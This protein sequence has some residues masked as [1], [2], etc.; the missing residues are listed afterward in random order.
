M[1]INFHLTGETPYVCNV[2]NKGYCSSSSLKKHKETKHFDL[3]YSNEIV[4]QGIKEHVNLVEIECKICNRFFRSQ[5]FGKHMKIHLT[6]R[7][8]FLCLVCNKNF[9]KNS[10]L[11][12][13]MRVHT[14]K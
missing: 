14:G 1:Y 6:E 10:H 11:E 8:E 9:Q 3:D 2:C 4:N 5:G 13:H 7:K 12:R